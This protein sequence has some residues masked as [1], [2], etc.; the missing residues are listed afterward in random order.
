LAFSWF[1]CLTSQA[2]NNFGWKDASGKTRNR[3]DLEEILGK[4][5]QW[6]LKQQSGTQADLSRAELEDAHLSGVNL[7]LANLTGTNLSGADLTGAILLGAT[8]TNA[9]LAN[10]TLTDAFL[11]SADLRGTSLNEADLTGAT[12]V[13]ARLIGAD[14]SDA[15][16]TRANLYNAN[17]RRAIFEPKALPESRDIAA[18]KHLELLTYED[19]PDG[20][21][22]LRAQFEDGGFREQER[23]ITYALKRREA[24]R[25]FEMC[26]SGIGILTNC[27][28]FVLNKILF[29]W[30][31]QYGM[32]PERPLIVGVL[33]WFVC[34]WVYFACIHARG[35]SGLYR[36]YPPKID[37]DPKTPSRV[38]RIS[39]QAT[40]Q[41]GWVR[42]KWSLMRKSMFFSLMCAFNIGFRDINFGRWLR[43]MTRQE[44]D[45]KAEG[46]PRVVA[47]VESLISV[48]LLALAILTYFGRPFG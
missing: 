39:P 37:E 25:S 35:G 26:T 46:L 47:G 36:I 23:K 43:L 28:S 18:A 24:Q 38:E 14:L 22:Q 6:V 30:T 33:L 7:A 27:S 15:N 11:F 19:N 8:M 16:L 29:D 42:R 41:S 48:G 21:V 2:Q 5:N 9:Y 13:G 20:L 40:G 45:M 44:F 3:S 4:H 1:W 31:C 10:A 17:L 12:L 32:S 34:S